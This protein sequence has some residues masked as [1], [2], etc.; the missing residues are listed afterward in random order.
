MVPL[1]WAGSN[2]YRHLITGITGKVVM[3]NLVEQ[4][5]EHF[6]KIA[7]VYAEA[8]KDAKH[9]LLKKMI[10]ENFFKNKQN[11]S[12]SCKRVL[13]PMCG[14]GEGGQIIK[15]YLTADIDYSGFDYSESMVESATEENP[16]ANITWADATAYE[17]SGQL[18]DWIVLIGGLHHVFSVSG[19][20]VSRLGQSLHPGGYFLNFE[21]TQNCWLTRKIRQSIYNKN[22]IFDEET[23]QGF[24]LPDLDAQFESAGFE[25]T[26]QVYPGLLAYVLFYNPDAFP[27][28]NIGGKWLVLATFWFDRLIWRTWIA[29]KLS[30]A[31]ITLWR[32]KELR[33]EK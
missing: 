5:R 32:K 12:S 20:V 2:I 8:R 25:K 14:I 23:E 29:K 28:L 15:N 17:H 13:E 9:L 19:D 1:T 3:G 27:I 24:D 33:N 26:D 18:F 30:F 11:L 16:D 31:T 22:D 6:N 7:T 21:P 10:W 4:Q